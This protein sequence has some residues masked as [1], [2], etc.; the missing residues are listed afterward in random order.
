MERPTISTG[1]GDDGTTGFLGNGRMRKSS[2]RAHALGSVDELNAALG[3][4]LSSGSL[5]SSLAENLAGIQ[6]VLFRLGTD[7]SA[8]LPLPAPA[9]RIMPADITGLEEWAKRLEDG[10][11]RLRRF[12]IPGGS[13]LSVRLHVARAVC[14]RAERWVSALREEGGVNPQI[15]IYL[16][17]L[18]DGLFLAAREANRAEGRS[19]EEISVRS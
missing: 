4:A 10:L 7:L 8:P 12:I 6:R 3:L 1:N 17:R 9:E 18:S 15:L 11:P 19:D 14:R 5:P 13:E 2:A 16:N